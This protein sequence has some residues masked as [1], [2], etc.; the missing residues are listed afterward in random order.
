MTMLVKASSKFNRPTKKTD[1]WHDCAGK[2]SSNLM[3]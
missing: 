2:A 1:V 3:A